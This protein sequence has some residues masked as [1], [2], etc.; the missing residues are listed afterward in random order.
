MRVLR[1]LL[2]VT[3]NA[4]LKERKVIAKTREG[5]LNQRPFAEFFDTS[6]VPW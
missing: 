1:V 4:N 6:R 5:K 2:A 3:Q